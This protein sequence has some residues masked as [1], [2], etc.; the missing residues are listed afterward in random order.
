[1]SQN[2]SWRNNE[3]RIRMREGATPS[4]PTHRKKTPNVVGFVSFCV[5][6]LMC[7]AAV[8]FLG[9]KEPLLGTIR[10]ATADNNR[11]AASESRQPYLTME[12]FEQQYS[13]WDVDSWNDDLNTV[14]IHTWGWLDSGKEQSQKEATVHVAPDDY[15]AMKTVALTK[16]W[17][18]VSL[19][20]RG[21]RDE[22]TKK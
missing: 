3:P 5:L 20:C 4:Q 13:N 7:V 19:I 22:R 2:Q 16:N 12:E 9:F 18:R 21:V 14:E 17:F 1:M 6:A 11:A 10:T 8:V 15:R